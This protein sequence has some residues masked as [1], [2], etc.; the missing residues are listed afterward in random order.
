MGSPK[1]LLEYRG[2]T[3]IGR[4]ARVLSA[5]CD[6]LVVVLGYHA[7]ALRPAVPNA[8]IAIN[9]APERGQLSSLQAGLAALPSAAEGFLFTP[10]DSPAVESTT[11]DRLAA[12]FQRRDP[13]TQLVIPRFKG[14]RGHP[15]FAT[16]AIANELAALP[17]TA[18]ARDVIRAHVAD[19]LYIDVDDPGILTD[20]D[21]REAYRVLLSEAAS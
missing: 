10:V 7:D 20:I 1:A 12:E 15:V 4:L 16:R 5:V 18:Q 11:V 19:T 3:F 9:P 6:P 14:R 2:E 21:D 8:T 13:A 17:L